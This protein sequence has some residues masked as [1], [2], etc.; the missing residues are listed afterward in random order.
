M[1]GL[2]NQSKPFT[3]FSVVELD[4]HRVLRVESD[5]AYGN[6]LHPLSGTAPGHLSWRWRVDQPVQ[7]A[8]LYR[9]SGE[10]AALKVCA[11]FDLPAERVPFLERQWV[12]L[13]QLRSAEK[14]PLATLC[15]VWDT[16]LP[17]NT[18][19]VSPFTHRIRSITQHGSGLGQWTSVT[20]DLSTDFLRAFGDE[21]RSVP[22]LVG[23]LV[24]ADADNTAS[25]SVG[26]LSDL[27]LD[28]AH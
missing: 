27:V 9:R 8:D 28:A 24:G 22:S 1:V 11:S 23:I 2:P 12:A 14:F 25:H 6:L 17:D 21:S 4:G 26:Y 18:L 13:M 10:D 19:V 3:R 7:H 5:R 15:Y 20:H 16:T